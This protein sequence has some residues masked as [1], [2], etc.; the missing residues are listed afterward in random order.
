VFFPFIEIH[1]PNFSPFLGICFQRCGLCQSVRCT[2]LAPFHNTTCGSFFLFVFFLP[3]TAGVIHVSPLSI[4]FASSSAIVNFLRVV[5]PAMHKKEYLAVIYESKYRARK[6]K[7]FPIILSAPSSV[8]KKFRKQ[9]S[10]SAK[11]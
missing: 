11:H 8:S 7:P 1:C 5:V 2:P 6:K 4:R 3:P 10:S 9:I